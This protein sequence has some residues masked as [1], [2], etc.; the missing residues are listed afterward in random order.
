MSD[1]QFLNF[2]ATLE[3]LIVSLKTQTE[4]HLGLLHI[5]DEKERPEPEFGIARHS[6]DLLAMLQEKTRGN[7]TLEEQRLLDNALTELRF[8]YIQAMEQ[9]QK[10]AAEKAAAGEI[11]TGEIKTEGQ[12]SS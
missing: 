8:R 9:H 6:I 11:K 5:G 2:P 1:Q 10:K 4:I 3:F 7:C 12:A